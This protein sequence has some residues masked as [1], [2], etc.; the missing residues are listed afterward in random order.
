MVKGTAEVIQ[1]PCYKALAPD[2]NH[3]DWICLAMDQLLGRLLVPKSDLGVTS[4][5][6]GAARRTI[7]F[8]FSCLV[9]VPIGRR[10][11][12]SLRLDCSEPLG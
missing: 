3:S 6:N 9:A 12:F 2:V 5:L 10:R 7:V 8:S 4:D 1:N 11:N